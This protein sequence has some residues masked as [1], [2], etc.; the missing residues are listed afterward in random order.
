VKV[1]LKLAVDKTDGRCRVAASGFIRRIARAPDTTCREIAKPRV[2]FGKLRNDSC[3]LKDQHHVDRRRK[4]GK[5]V[6][7]HDAKGRMSS[8]NSHRTITQR[9]QFLRAA[10]EI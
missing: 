7:I 9:V 4:N 5:S 2:A 10:V 1:N 8:E 6:S 3:R